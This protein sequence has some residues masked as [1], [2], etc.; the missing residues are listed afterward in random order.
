MPPPGKPPSSRPPTRSQGKGKAETRT[1]PVVQEEASVSRVVEKTGKALRVRMDSHEER[2]RVPVTD[3]FEEV[4]V[5]RVPI[6]RYVNERTGPREE[7][8]VVISPVFET[9]PVVE[10]RLLLKEE[11]RVVRH[12]REVQREEEVVLRKDI[13]VVERRASGQ[14]E[15]S[16]D[17]PDL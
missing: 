6:N 7:G 12:R 3:I 9:V 5:E 16:Q 4:S 15:W 8:G 2:Q 17:P 14:E 13:P 11:V 10:E 1:I